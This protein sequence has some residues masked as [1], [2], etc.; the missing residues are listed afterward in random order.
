ML[1]FRNSTD[2]YLWGLSTKGAEYMVSWEGTDLVPQAVNKAG[3][4]ETILL[5]EL[6]ANQ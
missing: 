2:I 5:F 4:T 6:S 3:Y 1:D